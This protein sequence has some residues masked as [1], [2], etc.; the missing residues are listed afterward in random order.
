[1]GGKLFVIEPDGE[2]RLVREYTEESAAIG[3][4]QKAV[5]GYIEVVPRFGTIALDGGSPVTCLAFANEEGKGRGLPFNP[6]ATALWA[7]A[8]GGPILDHL[9]GP[10][11]VLT[12]DA[13]FLANV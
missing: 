12:G 10:I 4:L 2:C 11:A 8:C 5:G 13:A 7:T 1:M 3:D 6:V 9:V